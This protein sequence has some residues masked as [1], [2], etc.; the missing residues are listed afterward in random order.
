MPKSTL[1]TFGKTSKD[2]AAACRA[3]GG[4]AIE[5]WV[6]N[7]HPVKLSDA[8]TAVRVD[9]FLAFMRDLDRVL[10]ESAAQPGGLL[11]PV[12][13]P[14]L[15]F[16]TVFDDPQSPS[17]LNLTPQAKV[18]HVTE[19]QDA[20]RLTNAYVEALNDYWEAHPDHDDFPRLIAPFPV[21]SLV[22]D[23][24]FLTP[25]LSKGL[26]RMKRLRVHSERVEYI[27]DARN[28]DDW[29]ILERARL[30]YFVLT[31]DGGLHGPEMLVDLYKYHGFRASDG[32]R[33][34]GYWQQA[35][36]VG[37]EEKLSV[38]FAVTFVS[39]F[40]NMLNHSHVKLECVVDPQRPINRQ[41]RRA[42]A[43]VERDH[44]RTAIRP[45]RRTGYEG[46]QHDVLEGRN[47]RLR[48]EH[49]VRAHPRTLR[50]DRYLRN[51]DGSPRTIKVSNFTRCKGNGSY[52]SDYD[53]TGAARL[54]ADGVAELE[55]GK[56]Q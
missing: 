34:A 31:T 13:L 8:I 53:F 20:I 14:D 19:D 32:T 37:P 10:D 46:L 21:F 56:A 26:E 47:V 23:Q 12:R 49:D 1:I 33:V 52:L 48:R 30:S 40:V 2:L 17:L 22:I 29:R 54:M 18:F 55:L 25:V 3:R 43:Y 35:E 28:D 51:P 44:Y 27:V 24:P 45:K 7:P 41:Q 9:D 39:A 6:I 50:A 16:N 4:R 5:G 38:V 11:A 15:V 36:A 42:Q